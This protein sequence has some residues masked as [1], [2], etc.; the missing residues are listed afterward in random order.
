MSATPVLH[1][2]EAFGLASEIVSFPTEHLADAARSGT[3]DRIIEHL[4]SQ[5]PYEMEWR[6]T[7]SADVSFRTLEAEYIRL[8]DVPD[9]RPCPLYTGVYASRRHDAM[10]ELLRFYRHFGLTVAPAAHDLPD[11]VPTVLE[12]L[13]FLCLREATAEHD[14]SPIQAARAD[15][16]ERHLLPWTRNTMGRLADRSPEPFYLSAIGFVNSI[17]NAEL[18]FLRPAERVAA[19]SP[20]R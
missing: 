20:S 16:I 18:S 13:Q 4:S 9:G 1:V 17:A 6:G 15:V 7:M 10:E 5:L 12:F 14:P 2:G 19:H 3:L 11:S 8:F